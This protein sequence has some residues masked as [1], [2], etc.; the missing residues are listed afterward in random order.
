MIVENKLYYDFTGIT[1]YHDKGYKGKGITI[2]VI[3]KYEHQEEI[4][5]YVGN[6]L[7]SHGR[8][9]C[10][11]IKE[12]APD[13]RI[14]CLKYNTSNKQ[15]VEWIK[16]NNPDLI[17]ISLAG[18]EIQDDSFLDIEGYNII[19]ATGNNGYDYAL[20]PANKDFTIAV[21]SQMQT[22]GNLTSYSNQGHDTLGCNGY[23][24]NSVGKVWSPSGTSFSSPWITGMMACYMSSLNY[25]MEFEEVKAFIESNNNE[26]KVLILPDV[27]ERTNMEIKMHIGSKA[28]MVDGVTKYMDVAPFIDNNRTFVPLRAISEALGCEVQWDGIK[29][30]ITIKG[31]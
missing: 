16:E 7:P 30:E 5:E 22:S 15:Y 9:V 23:I 27:V 13:A 28:Y 14:I 24:K 3:D 26:N 29:K 1:K 20:Y 31:V 2:A 8:N 12:I 10:E 17:N 6:E 21:G 4:K 19:C 18:R 11:V 25:K